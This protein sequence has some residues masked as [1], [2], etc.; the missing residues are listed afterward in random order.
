[1]SWGYGVGPQT[2]IPL[3][4]VGQERCFWTPRMGVFEL[5]N[6]NKC[7]GVLGW[8]PKHPYLCTLQAGKGVFGYLGWGCLNGTM[9][10]NI[11]GF[12]GGAPNT[13]TSVPYKPAKVFLDTWDGGVLTAQ[14]QKISFGFW[15]G[16]PNPPTA[17][18]CGPAKVFM[19]TYDCGLYLCLCLNCT[20]PQ[21]MVFGCW[22]GAPNTHAYHC[23]LQSGK[24]VLGI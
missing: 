8:P 24:D 21:K 11:V 20:M 9:P 3:Y 22:G 13:H 19:D 1:M 2:P 18:P 12:C 14:C 4:P 16:A 15:G 5:H 17:V 23:T 6:A 7:H 10:R